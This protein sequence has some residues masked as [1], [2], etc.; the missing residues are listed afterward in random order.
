[1]RGIAAV[2]VNDD[3]S[4]GK[5]AVAVRTAD[6][7]TSGG[8]YQDVVILRH[9]TVRQCGRNIFFD[10]RTEFVQSHIRTVLG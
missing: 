10:Q 1:M 4:A 3:F 2:S 7:K 8:V 6:N 5:S 9:P